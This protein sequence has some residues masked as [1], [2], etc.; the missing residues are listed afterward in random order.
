MELCNSYNSIHEEPI[1][2]YSSANRTTLGRIAFA[3]SS[4]IVAIQTDAELQI[5]NMQ[6]SIY[7]LE[8][9]NRELRSMLDVIR[10]EMS[11]MRAD[12]NARQLR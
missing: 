1:N 5:G 9:D 8:M 10:M 12:I 6:A 3:D 2:L 7:R 4:N 11:V